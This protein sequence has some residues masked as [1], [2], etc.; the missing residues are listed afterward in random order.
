MDNTVVHFLSGKTRIVV[1]H[2]LMSVHHVD[3]ILYLSDGEVKFFGT[4]DELEGT[5]LELELQN[6]NPVL[7]KDFDPHTLDLPIIETDNSVS[8][9]CSPPFSPASPIHVD[10]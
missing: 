7:G 4:Y 8:P 1:T 2:Q 3:R 6:N 10:R 9:V 5:N